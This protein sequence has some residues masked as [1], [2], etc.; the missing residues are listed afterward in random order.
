M[1]LCN[2]KL[3]TGDLCYRES[4]KCRY[5]KVEKIE[6][7]PNGSSNNGKKK[8]K[9]YGLVKDEKLITDFEI[10]P[11]VLFNGETYQITFKTKKEIEKVNII[12]TAE[13]TNGR[14]NKCDSRRK[15]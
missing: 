6:E 4:G 10:E 13:K 5:H 14:T 12:L 8:R 3:K 7:D 15:Y 1:E 9:K 2:T 11:I